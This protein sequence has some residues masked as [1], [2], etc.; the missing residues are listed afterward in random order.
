MA[1]S[2]KMNEYDAQQKMEK[3]NKH[4]VVT[5]P[6]IVVLGV[7]GAGCNA[8]DNMI[9][10]GIGDDD[11][12]FVAANTDA[13]A[14]E[15]CASQAVQ[16]QLGPRVTKGLGAGADPEVGAAAARESIEEVVDTFSDAHM[17]FITAGAGG[18]TGS[19]GA[20]EIAKAAREKGILTIGFVTRPFSFEG[21]GRAKAAQE[22]IDK[23]QECVDCLIIVQNQ[24]LLSMNNGSL[25][26]TE[27][28]A[29]VDAVLCSGVAGIVNIIARHGIVNVD[30]QDALK[31]MKNRM[32]R[33]VFGVGCA[34]GE[35]AGSRAAAIALSN[36]LLELDEETLKKVDTALISVTGGAGLSLQAVEAAVEYLRGQ[37][38]A[39]DDNLIVGMAVIPEMK[40]D[41]V[42]VCIFASCPKTQDT[43]VVEQ[44]VQHSMAAH[45]KQLLSKADQF[46]GE[47]GPKVANPNASY[48]D[49]I[50][51]RHHPSLQESNESDIFQTI[52][53]QRNMSAEKRTPEKSA[54][55]I[56]PT[57]PK[58]ADSGTWFDKLLGRK[59][60][61]NK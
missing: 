30:F 25:P 2:P 49:T 61:F 10:A 21:R 41:A 40:A 51:G 22:S 36:P 57:P 53:S 5:K 56:A 32:S 15:R 31:V 54:P 46:V 60:L 59:S 7:G 33:V 18:G 19:G 24:N 47:T 16:I 38:N 50:I 35:N 12:V 37:I 52:K 4:G 6:K 20:P 58:Q 26:V 13:Q 17:L 11:V 8:I 27:G 9:N 45:M 48:E 44:P 42:E 55:N 23:L 29:M 14:L 43:K 1:R 3:R 39:E 34:E 28:F